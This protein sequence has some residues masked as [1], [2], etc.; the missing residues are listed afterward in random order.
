[1]SGVDQF[2]TLTRQYSYRHLPSRSAVEVHPV[3]EGRVFSQCSGW[4]GVTCFGVW[5]T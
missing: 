2:H 5:E 3:G 4:A 1:M